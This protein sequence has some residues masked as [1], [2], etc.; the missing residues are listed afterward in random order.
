MLG[1]KYDDKLDDEGREFLALILEGA[2]RMEALL[3]ALLEYSRIGHLRDEPLEP[4]SFEKALEEVTTSLRLAM[5]E[6]GAVVTHDALPTAPA[7]AIEVQQLLQNLISNAIKYRG[8]KPPRVHVSCS[9]AD[10]GWTFSVRDNGIGIEPNYRD[11][12]FGVFERLHGREVPGT[13]IG[14]ATCK[15]IVENHGGKI[16]VESTA[17]EGST[18]LFT[19][20]G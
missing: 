8:E 3:S 20:R 17:G 13:G 5:E 1:R 15:K 9:R 10:G 4:V 14:L 18:F 2:T 11:K 7:R 16:W 6:S 19:M 12:V